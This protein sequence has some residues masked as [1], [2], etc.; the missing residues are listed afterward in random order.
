MVVIRGVDVTAWA[1]QDKLNRQ[2][3][4]GYLAAALDRLAEWLN[5]QKSN[6]R[7]RSAEVSG[8]AQKRDHDGRTFDEIA[9]NR[10]QPAELNADPAPDL[11]SGIA[12]QPNISADPEIIRA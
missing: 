11:A 7:I 9:A 2:V 5:R 4:I 1:T 12:P 8:P 10:A 6:G 3:A